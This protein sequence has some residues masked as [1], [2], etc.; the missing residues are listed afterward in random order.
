[1]RHGKGIGLFFYSCLLLAAGCYGH[2]KYLDYFYPGLWYA[3]PEEF[4]GA[5]AEDDTG[6]PAAAMGAQKITAGTR[7]VIRI[8][9]LD[10]GEER[11]EEA[12]LPGQYV[13]MDR[14]Q[15][16]Q[17]I[18][19]DPDRQ[20]LREKEEGLVSVEVVS[21]SPERVVIAKAYR[22]TPETRERYRLVLIGNR[23]TVCREDGSVFLRTQIDGRAL[24]WEE[25][26]D[27]LNGEKT[28]SREE[29]EKFLVTYA[30]T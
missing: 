24:P 12:E 21:F 9:D 16:L 6:A 8:R 5:P 19:E 26:R 2:I 25:R 11:E 7:L 13:G 10:S 14:E 28:I 17:Y 20:S 22:Q 18:E 27:I 30:A 1:M 29:L 3:A 23:I 4:A 15:L